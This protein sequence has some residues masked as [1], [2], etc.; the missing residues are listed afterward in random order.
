MDTCVPWLRCFK[1]WFAFP[2]IVHTGLKQPKSPLNQLCPWPLLPLAP[3]LLPDMA[4]PSGPITASVLVLSELLEVATLVSP[5]SIRSTVVLFLPPWPGCWYWHRGRGSYVEL[6]VNPLV[7]SMFRFERMSAC[8]WTGTEQLVHS[9]GRRALCP[10]LS[11]LAWL[12]AWVVTSG[13]ERVR[14]SLSWT[15]ITL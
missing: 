5:G 13:T 3:P 12:L 10:S 15:S 8:W 1:S 14:E 11:G 7:L 6:I 9:E 2:K 4:D